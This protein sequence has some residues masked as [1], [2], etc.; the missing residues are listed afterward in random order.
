MLS[1]HHPRSYF[2]W[3]FFMLNQVWIDFCHIN[4]ALSISGRLKQLMLYQ[5]VQFICFLISLIHS[6]VRVCSLL[7]HGN[8]S[9]CI[10][11]EVLTA[12]FGSEVCSPCISNCGLSLCLRWIWA[13]FGFRSLSYY[14]QHLIA[15]PSF[16]WIFSWLVSQL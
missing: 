14:C 1:W 10:C 3:L 4:F 8:L 2:W 11:V 6:L 16:L 12:L 5:L 7:L 13:F 15:F 9:V